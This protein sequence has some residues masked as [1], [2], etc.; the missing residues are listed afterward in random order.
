LLS[1]GI[2]GGANGV[3]SAIVLPTLD[4]AHFTIYHFE[5]YV[6]VFALFASGFFVSIAKWIGA[7]PLPLKTITTSTA[8]VQQGSREPVVTTTVAETHTEKIPEAPK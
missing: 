2:S 6:A 7:N 1:A 4:A 3:A 8:V 5:F